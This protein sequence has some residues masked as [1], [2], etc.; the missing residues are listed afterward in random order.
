MAL[1]ELG[2]DPSKCISRRYPMGLD[3]GRELGIK[4]VCVGRRIDGCDYFIQKF[5]DLAVH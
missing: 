4:T 3:A 5:E 1:D 2:V